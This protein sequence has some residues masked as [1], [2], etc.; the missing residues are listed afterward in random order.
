[1]ATKLLDCCV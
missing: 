1:M